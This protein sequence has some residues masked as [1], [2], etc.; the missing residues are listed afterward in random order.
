MRTQLI[1]TFSLLAAIAFLPSWAV[2]V[3][4]LAALVFV[5]L[6][7]PARKRQQEHLNQK[8]ASNVVLFSAHKRGRKSIL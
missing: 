7:R 1:L 2:G 8:I 5:L 6:W 4:A 3:G